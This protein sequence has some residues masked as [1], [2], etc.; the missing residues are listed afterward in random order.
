MYSDIWTRQ[1]SDALIAEKFQTHLKN[2]KASETKKFNAVAKNQLKAQ[3]FIEVC[4]KMG[5]L[6]KPFR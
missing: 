6:N 2:F 4:A 3:Q 1:N 5:T